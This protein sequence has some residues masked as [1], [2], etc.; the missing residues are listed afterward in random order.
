[1]SSGDTD[2]LDGWLHEVDTDDDPAVERTGPPSWR[3]GV[4]GLVAV[5]WLAVAVDGVLVVTGDLLGWAGGNA[6]A[7]PGSTPSS[8]RQE[9][10]G[11]LLALTARGVAVAAIGGVLALWWRRRLAATVSGGA[12]V[13]ALVVGL[14]TYAMAAE[15]GPSRPAW[16]DDGPRGCVELS[17]EPSDCP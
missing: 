15:D 7:F 13:V 1:M 17:G 14:T 3:S 5:V 2:G 4:L 11:D 8:G 12:A 16:E 10:R 9:L 6:F